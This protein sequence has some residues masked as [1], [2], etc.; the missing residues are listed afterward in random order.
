MDQ[1]RAASTAATLKQ[2]QT[3]LNHKEL[4]REVLNQPQEP[5]SKHQ[6]KH[7]TPIP[8]RGQLLRAMGHLL[9]CTALAHHLLPFLVLFQGGTPCV[10]DSQGQKVLAGAL[11]G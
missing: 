2:Q 9:L 7:Q 1:G 10:L 4:F 11:K 6:S 3:N 8:A 5:A